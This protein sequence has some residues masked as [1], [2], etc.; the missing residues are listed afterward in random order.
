[1]I[2]RVAGDVRVPD[3]LPQIIDSVCLA[4]GPAQRA[5]IYHSGRGT[6]HKRVRLAG[7]DGSFPD[8]LTGI[9][10]AEG[11]AVSGAECAQVE[12][13]R[14]RG[15]QKCMVVSVAGG[16]TEACDLPSAIY[17]PCI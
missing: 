9:V 16:L 8:N 4:V 11:R 1:M 13:A 6:P 2:G 14:A 3:D 15:P 10:Q 17:A 7:G 5:E 12:H